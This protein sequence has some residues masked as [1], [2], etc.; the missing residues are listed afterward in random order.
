MPLPSSM[1]LSLRNSRVGGGGVANKHH[2]NQA[3]HF[4]A[5]IMMIC[6]HNSYATV[7]NFHPRRVLMILILL[8]QAT[9]FIQSSLLLRCGDIESNPGPETYPSKLYIL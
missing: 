1:M 4:H 9:S 3:Y 2:E 7:D 6:T 8:L 5:E